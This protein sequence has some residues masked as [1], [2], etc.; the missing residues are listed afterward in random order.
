MI[1]APAYRPAREAADLIDLLE[2]ELAAA[3]AALEYIVKTDKILHPDICHVQ[4]EAILGVHLT[5]QK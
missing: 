2:H 4:A 5:A 1:T 3:L